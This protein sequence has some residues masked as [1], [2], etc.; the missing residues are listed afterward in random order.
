MGKSD[1]QRKREQRE[2]D[3]IRAAEWVRNGS[4]EKFW[5]Q[6]KVKDAAQLDVP[7]LLEAQEHALDQAFW[8]RY[9]WE[10]DPADENFVSFEEGTEELRAFIKSQGGVI[11]ETNFDEA[12][13]LHEVQPQ[14]SLWRDFWRDPRLVVELQGINLPTAIY[15]TYGIATAPFETLVR[16]FES[17]IR[18]HREAH[19]WLARY[20]HTD[21]ARAQSIMDTQHGVISGCW[22]CLF[23]AK[24]RERE[25]QREQPC[26]Q[27][28]EPQERGVQVDGELTE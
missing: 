18:R 3:K 15:A 19:E 17:G 26:E 9:G 28:L 7:A 22:Q 27:I 16:K 21:P 8:V 5:E 10:V 2:R 20:A 23:A 24:Q 6:N 25:Q 14:W 4:R 1:K 13:A 12:L 11:K